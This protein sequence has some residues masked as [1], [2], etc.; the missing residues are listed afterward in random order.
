MTSAWRGPKAAPRFLDPMMALVERLDRRRRRIR[1]VHDGS[2][3]GIEERRHRGAEVLLADGVHVPHGA[4]LWAIHFDNAR[5]SELGADGW[6]SRAHAAGRAD[7]VALAALLQARDAAQR[8]I[9]LVGVTMLAS[10]VVRSGFE[11][12]DRPQSIWTRLEDWY[13][14]SLLV[15]WAPGGRSRLRRGHGP[16]RSREV[17]LST[18]ALL[19]RYA[20]GSAPASGPPA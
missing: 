18:A 14:R 20:S 11:A 15:R 17:W 9:A 10:L 4:L 13:L 8:P 19:R 6:Q 2:L 5:L 16:I 12:R 3:L 1:P 7:L